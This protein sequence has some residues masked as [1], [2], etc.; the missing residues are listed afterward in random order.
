M[1]SAD[2]YIAWEY[3]VPLIAKVSCAVRENKG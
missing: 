2:I 3:E 1:H